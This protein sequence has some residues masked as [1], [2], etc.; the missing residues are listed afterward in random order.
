MMAM[1]MMM[2]LAIW[3]WISFIFKVEVELNE[4]GRQQRLENQPPLTVHPV[5]ESHIIPSLAY[6]IS[7]CVFSWK[8]IIL[9]ICQNKNVDDDVSD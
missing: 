7:R 3:D 8:K 1:M 6:E 5:Y 2:M 9:L 4:R